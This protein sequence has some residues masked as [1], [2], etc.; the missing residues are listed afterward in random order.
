MKS[1]TKMENK[2]KNRI[3]NM[4]LKEAKCKGKKYKRFIHIYTQQGLYEGFIH[5]LDCIHMQALKSVGT[6][7]KIEM[8]S[9]NRDENITIELKSAMRR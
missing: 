3:T 6:T 5:I 8:K 2:Y 4:Q 1:K 9:K 7:Y